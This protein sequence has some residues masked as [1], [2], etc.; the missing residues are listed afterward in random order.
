[1]KNN[2]E[3]RLASLEAKQSDESNEWRIFIMPYGVTDE[4]IMGFKHN[5]TIVRREVNE[6]IESLKE[7]IQ[8]AITC[9]VAMIQVIE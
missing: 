8:K 5:E 4:L 1:M 2:L 9:R 6:S 7:R 3:Q